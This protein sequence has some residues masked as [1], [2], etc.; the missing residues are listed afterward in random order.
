MNPVFAQSGNAENVSI[1]TYGTDWLYLLVPLMVFTAIVGYLAISGES[2]VG[3]ITGLLLRVSHSLTRLTGL[4]AWSAGGLGVGIFALLVAVIGFYW[5][6]AWHIELGRDQF[7]FTPAHMMIVAGLGF[8][9]LAA[10]TSIVLATVTNADV[11]KRLGRIV[12]PLSAI[13]IALLGLGALSGFPLDEFWHQAYGVDVTMWGP[14][15]LVMISGASLTPIALCLMLTESGRIESPNFLLKQMRI[16][17]TGAVLI[18]LSTWTG[19]FDF[20]VPQFQQLYH[21]VLVAMAGSTALV[22]ARKVLGPGGALHAVLVFLLA[23]GAVAVLLGTSL[24]LVIPRFPLYIGSAVVVEAV[25]RFS[26]ERG[27]RSALIA[28]LGVGT[29]GLAAEWGWMQIWGRHPWNAALFPTVLI[30]LLMAVVG[31][32]IGSAMADVLTRKKVAIPKGVLAFAGVTLV[33]LLALPLPR[34][35]APIEAVIEA[36][37]QRE[38]YADVTVTLDP[39][40]AADS[41]DWFEALS[42]QGGSLQVTPMEEVSPG[43]F[44]ATQP[45]PVSGELKTLVRMAKNDVLVAVPVY[46]PP[47][48]E[49]SAPEIPLLARREATFARDTDLLLR[50]TREGESLPAI[51]A[52]S[53]ILLLAITW[54][55]GFIWAFG[56]VARRTEAGGGPRSG[57]AVVHRSQERSRRAGATA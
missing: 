54:V 44:E 55:V 48:P 23:R 20:G 40:D 24:G 18:G 42:W 5:D 28:G 52:Y 30:A 2:R 51:L 26:K 31:A 9:L 53:A 12:V 10:V 7:I 47:D 36:E 39:A 46:L 4:P 37:A 50:E 43:V 17:I 29:V 8:I 19:E 38:G 13:P 45:V 25:A 41:S 57:G 14:T 33:A 22:L 16:A 49:I 21:P 6:V 34:T 35:S 11:G 1:A 3:G 56:K 32:L 15:H 27:L